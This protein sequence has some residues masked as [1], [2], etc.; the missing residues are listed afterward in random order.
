[1]IKVEI[2]SEAGYKF[3]RKKIRQEIGR[4]VLE[5]GIRSDVEVCVSVVGEV[6]MKSLHKKYMETE[7]ATDVLSF[8]L[9]EGHRNKT[10]FVSVP[11]GI[12]RLGDIVICYPVATVQAEAGD[13]T[14]DEEMTF[15]AG[16]GC[17]HLLGVHHE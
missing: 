7:E 11:D 13:K 17:L 6:K 4:I 12:L 8:P 10:N 9:E 14:V 1:M 16:H 3:D 15:L 2:Y 5:K